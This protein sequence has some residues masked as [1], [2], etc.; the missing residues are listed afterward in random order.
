MTWNRRDALRVA[1]GQYRA[2]K[3]TLP[4]KGRKE[5]RRWCLTSV[6]WWTEGMVLFGTRR[7]WRGGGEMPASE[8]EQIV[9]GCW[10]LLGKKVKSGAI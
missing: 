8:F 10:G 2:A 5:I 1:S 6:F 3:I 7:K 9:R 4:A